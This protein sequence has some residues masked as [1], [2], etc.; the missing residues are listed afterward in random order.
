MQDQI[1][2]YEKLKKEAESLN[3]RI[4]HISGRLDAARKQYVA[5][6][7]EARQKFGVDSI[8]ALEA[9]AKKFEEE[10]RAMLE[11]FER[12]IV[13]VR[14]EVERIEAALKEAGV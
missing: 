12:N 4:G 7:E 1:A 6:R 14:A 10:N 5:L 8:E 11:E 13:R 2:R 3:G 9:L